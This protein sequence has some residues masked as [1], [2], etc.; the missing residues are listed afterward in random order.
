MA[1]NLGV[2]IPDIQSEFEVVSILDTDLYKFT[3]QQAVFEYY[4]TAQAVY[5]FVHRDEGRQ[6]PRACVE[7]FQASL[8]SFTEVHLEQDERVWLQ[9]KCNYLKPKYL[10]YLQSYRFKPEQIFVNFIPCSNDPA[11]GSVEIEVRGLWLE[12]I[13]WEVPLM[14][15]ISEIYF[16][17]VD[18]DWD[19]TGQEAFDKATCFFDARCTLSDYGTCRR[20]SFLAHDLVLNGIIQARDAHEWKDGFF[21]TSNVNGYAQAYF[22]MRYN[23]NPIGIMAHEWFM[24]CAITMMLYIGTALDLWSKLYGKDLFVTL[25]D[26]FSTEVFYREFGRRRANH[27]DALR[28]DSGDP[29]VFAPRAKQMYEERGIDHTQKGIIYSDSLD[30][31]KAKALHDQ[32]QQLEFTK[33]SFGIGT[34]LMNDFKTKSSGYKEQSHAVITVITLGAIDGKECVKLS[35]EISKHIGVPEAVMKVKETYQVIMSVDHW[36][37]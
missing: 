33:C 28:Q 5:R 15:C 19:C 31:N 8:N 25:T 36:Y 18:Q 7:K 21:G 3:M 23:L 11:M 13:L 35:D 22:A 29:K 1:S 27:W 9:D 30:F 32:C 26:T 4:P 37:L 24:G 16:L 14:A 12:T 17:Y 2:P 10:D 6:F 34:W 20:R